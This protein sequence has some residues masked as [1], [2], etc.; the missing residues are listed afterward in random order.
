MASAR[1]RLQS[2]L[3]HRV[4]GIEAEALSLK[5]VNLLLAR[6]HQRS[7][8]SVVA[9][10]PFGLVVDPSNTCRLACPGCVH[11]ARAEAMQRF[12]WPNGTLTEAR[13]AALLEHYGP[14]AVGVYFCNYGEPL[15]NLRTPHLIR[16][17]KRY[18][19]S[20]RLSTSLS[21]KKFDA[22]AYAAS[23]LDFMVMSVDGATQ[24]VYSR[25]RRNGNLE[26]VL[27]N[28]RALVEAKRRL[29]THT[30]VLSWNFLAFEHNIHQIPQA[31]ELARKIGA[32]QFRVVEPFD[33]TWDDPE[34]RVA[35]VKGRVQRLDWLSAVRRESN[36]NPFPGEVARE[37]I[38]RAYQD[39]F[40]LPSDTEDPPESG[41]ACHWL[42]QNMV[43]DARGRILP[44]CGAPAKGTGL[45][46][47]SL[48]DGDS[49]PYNSPAYQQAR[50]S[51]RDDRSPADSGSYCAR[52]E[53]DQ[54]TVNIGS[55][56]IRHFFREVDA[57]YF[58][59]RSLQV[60]APD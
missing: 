43:M 8:H 2:S 50:R 19:L 35:E 49:G 56:E 34:I 30:P 17:A 59:R 51:F 52:C 31:R 14:S 45:V 11:S 46:F 12:D 60:V 28:M 39:P 5:L 3:E 20:A 58:D 44:C 4:G 25:F 57:G 7:R 27:T 33:V 53:W 10:R 24:D 32:D 15:L 55:Y 1:E 6:Y 23:G 29:G 41:H 48:E 18:L 36:W 47:G 13:F 16:M 38:H 9:S 21:V 40:A 42:Y 54:E 22:E 26:L 37:A